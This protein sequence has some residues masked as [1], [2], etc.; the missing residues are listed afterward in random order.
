NILTIFIT[1]HFIT[2]FSRI[3]SPIFVPAA[4]ILILLVSLRGSSSLRERGT[5][6]ELRYQHF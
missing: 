6:Q 3:F 2:I 1:P 5:G 4:P